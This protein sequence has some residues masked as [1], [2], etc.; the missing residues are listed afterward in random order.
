MN[1]YRNNNEDRRGRGNCNERDPTEEDQPQAERCPHCG[2][3]RRTGE[4]C[5][6]YQRAVGLPEQEIFQFMI[7]EDIDVC[8]AVIQAL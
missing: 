7:D 8:V 6:Q 1:F 5:T 2:S 4:F 3:R